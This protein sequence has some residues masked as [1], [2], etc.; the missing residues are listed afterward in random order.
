MIM[1]RGG[2]RL[3]VFLFCCGICCAQQVLHAQT[4]P[5][6]DEKSKYNGKK[7]FRKAAD[8]IESGIKKDN[9][10]TLASGYFDLG[11]TYYEKGEL[12]KSE[13]YYNRAKD[14]YNQVNDADGVA[15][16]S[17]ALAQVQEELHKTK[18]AIS[19]Y[20]Q[21]AASFTAAGNS[22]YVQMN[23]NDISRLKFADS[24]P[25]QQKLLDD[26]L[27]LVINTG[28]STEV[29][30]NLSRRGLYNVTNGN[31]QLAANDF[32]SAYR[33]SYGIPAQAIRYNQIATQTLVQQRD[34]KQAIALKKDL[35]QQPYIQASSE[36]KAKE[37]NSLADIYLK[38]KQDSTAIRLLNESYELSVKNGHT[39]E[40]RLSIERLDS[41]FQATGRK[42]RSLK[43]YKDFLLRLPTVIA[44][45]SSLADDRVIAETETR[46]R[47]LEDEKQLKDDLIRRKN[48]F[49]YW[50]IGTVV[51]LAL[52]SGIVFFMLRK[53]RV[54]NRKIALQSLR[55]EM[56]PH[57]IFNSLNSINQFIANN[58][59]LE[60]NR[61][62]TRFST[63]MR[64]V[65]ENSKNDFVQLSKEIELL[66]HYLELEKSRFA[67]KFDYV[68]EIDDSLVGGD[69][70]FIPGML[71]QPH[72]ENS[73]W[74]GLRY[75]DD[76]G[77]LQLRF[78]RTAT[79]LEVLIEDNGI[80]IEASRKAKTANQ[81]QHRGRGI[82][83]TQERISILNELYHQQIA[84][85]VTDKAAPD[86]GVQIRITMPLLKN[87][88]S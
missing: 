84:C 47:Q 16:S 75:M 22:G 46:I 80:G 78:I 14:L 32:K 65:M 48:I 28:D 19:N 25:M 76:K 34:F 5:E 42:D 69:G 51:I 50:L 77:L 2:L 63:L 68:L 54:R 73:I 74:H 7:G 61:Y 27:K 31:I 82:T 20:D 87:D 81:Q 83:N 15:R 39:L 4:A 35:L 86:H 1:K 62:L 41:I 6:A 70:L 57:F 52:L 49:N 26:N 38:T 11:K 55:R 64:R 45:D 13:Q 17:R 36:L 23:R 33:Y 12:N 72:L 24:M 43:L 29:A 60:A 30:G 71:I 37:I 10:D 40:A 44:K 53:L 85:V 18:E 59:E 58:N 56:N 79:G 9:P 88:Q 67:D 3:A 8:K 66:Q 21:S